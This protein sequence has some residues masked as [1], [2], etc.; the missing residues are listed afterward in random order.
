MALWDTLKN[1]SG[2]NMIS[3]FLDPQKPYQEAEKASRR[4]Y[5]EGRGYQLPYQQHGL[6]QYG[7]LTNAQNALLNPGELENQWANQYQTSPYAKQLLGQNQAQGMDAASQ[8]GL[9]GSS[10]ALNNIQQG[11]GNIVS[12]DRQ[13]F[14]NDLMQKYMAGLGIGK[15]IYGTG[16]NTAGNLGNQAI[17]QGRDTAGLRYG[18]AAAPGAQFAKLL[19]MG[20]D[21]GGNIATGG[22]YGAGKGLM[23]ASNQFN[24]APMGY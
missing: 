18:E 19:G 13:A 1:L 22:M 7:T 23:G 14:M 2:F 11:A 17:N 4:G 8:M 16:A 9:L 6:D 3:S 10:A 5:E 24:Q 20:V 21:I 12:A 15:D